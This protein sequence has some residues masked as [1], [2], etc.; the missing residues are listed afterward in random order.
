MEQTLCGVRLGMCACSQCRIG[1]GI[2][3]VTLES[4]MTSELEPN[5]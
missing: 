3:C 4:V 2:L 5:Q 1:R